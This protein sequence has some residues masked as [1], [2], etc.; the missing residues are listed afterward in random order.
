MRLPNEKKDGFL[1]IFKEGNG[2][3]VSVRQ[4]I[5]S[6]ESGRGVFVSLPTGLSSYRPF[7]RPYFCPPR[8]KNFL[9]TPLFTC[10]F[11][12]CAYAL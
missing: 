8:Y 2:A 12:C 3:Y 10:C 4:R 9:T 6:F 11:A 1:H 5:E 7:I